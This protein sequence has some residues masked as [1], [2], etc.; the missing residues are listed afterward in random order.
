MLGMMGQVMA[1]KNAQQQNVLGQQHLQAYQLENQQRQRAL[2]AQKAIGNAFTKN[3]KM[4]EDGNIQVDHMGVQRDLNAAGYGPEAMKVDTERRADLKAG[5]ETHEAETKLHTAQAARLGSLAGSVP[6]VDWASPQAPAQSK[7]AHDALIRAAQQAVSEKLLDPATA[8][9]LASAE[10]S[11]EV[12]QQLQQWGVGAM[13]SAQQGE[14]FNRH[15]T[16]AREQ[17][18]ADA[19]LLEHKARLPGIQ[20]KSEA[21]V[22]ENIS[23]QLAAAPTVGARNTLVSAISPAMRSQYGQLP[24]APDSVPTDEDRTRDNRLGMTPAQ[25]TGAD[26][27]DETILIRQQLA[28]QA[29]TLHE[30]ETTLQHRETISQLADQATTESYTHGGSTIDHVIANVE[31]PA[32]Y[33]G[34]HPIGKYRGEVLD[35]LKKR[36]SG[37]ISTEGAAARN[38]K[39]KPT[40]VIGPDGKFTLRKPG[41]GTPARSPAVTIPSA[42][43]ATPTATAA[44]PVASTATLP[45]GGGKALDRA[46]AMQFYEAAGKD[47]VKARELAAQHHWN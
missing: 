28:D 13:T 45:E 37:D 33:Q 27:R 2:D 5:F 22:R 40:I 9:K 1:M 41:A 44:T 4:G 7:A 24:G 21:E 11:P 16:Q 34:D 10:Y 3:T 36:K 19:N 47:P 12:E 18:L 29:K 42:A 46:T 31:N 14:E 39:L 43:P 17:S 26:Q 32:F 6:K 35:A 30:R 20:A 38:E 8:Q 23:P 25:A 15:L